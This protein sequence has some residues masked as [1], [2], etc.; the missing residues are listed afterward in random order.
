[1]AAAGPYLLAKYEAYASWGQHSASQG[2]SLADRFD[3]FCANRFIIGDE[4]EVA[5][6]IARYREE[7]GVDHFLARVQWPG[8]GQAGVLDAIERLGRVSSKLG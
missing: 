2:P 3:E 4:A 6:E 1:M 5:D 8:F 7:F